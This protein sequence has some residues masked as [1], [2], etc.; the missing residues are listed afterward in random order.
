MELLKWLIDYF[1][2]L[3]AFRK[4]IGYAEGDFLQEHKLS[5]LKFISEELCHELLKNCTEVS[6]G[7]LNVYKLFD[8][9][10]IPYMYSSLTTCTPV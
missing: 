3:C 1:Q 2:A 9:T 10:Y 5:A 8:I 7:S 4:A 6:R